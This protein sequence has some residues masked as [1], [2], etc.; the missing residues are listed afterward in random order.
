M[1]KKDWFVEEESEW[2]LLDS[3]EDD[4]SGLVDEAV[5]FQLFDQVNCIGHA[6]LSIICLMVDY[7]YQ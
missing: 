4:T 2:V 1:E 7:S 3:N 6:K 5:L